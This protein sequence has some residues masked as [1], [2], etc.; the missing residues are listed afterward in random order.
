MKDFCIVGSGISGATIAKLLSKKYSVELFDKARG[1]GGRSSNKRH[2]KASSFDHGAQ[3]I[4]PKN[5]K[6]KNF[7]VKLKEQNVLKIW[8]GNHIDFTKNQRKKINKYIGKKG[9]NDI[10]K[11]LL[12]GLKVNLS[13]AIMSINFNNGYW[14]VTLQN[15]KKINFKNLII[16]CPFPQVINLAKKYLPKKIKKLKVKMQPNITV[17]L[18]FKN[19]NNFSISSI[20]LS[21]KKIGWIANENS[22]KRFKSKELLLTLQS[23]VQWANRHI[24]NYKKNKKKTA[25]LLIEYFSNLFGFETGNIVFYNIHGWKYS[26]NFN[27]TNI[28]SYWTNKYNLGLCGDWFLG[29]KIED[30]WLSANDLFIEINKKKPT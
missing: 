1:V 15:N 17:M 9:N 18:A 28:K 21:E 11:H 4:S 14:S 10:S 5:T 6:F 27:K 29:P 23:S 16:T 30:A 20:K 3:Y 22:K 2:I 25:F 19:Y 7:I 13:S 12:K 26:Y 24:N 8:N